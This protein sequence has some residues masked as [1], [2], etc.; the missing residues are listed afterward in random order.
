MFQEL[1]KFGDKYK[2]QDKNGDLEH[3]KK[4]LF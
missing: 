2:S 4:T 3:P 1:K